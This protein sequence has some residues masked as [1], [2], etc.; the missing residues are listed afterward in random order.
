MIS[1]QASHNC[2]VQSPEKDELTI[3]NYKNTGPIKPI[4][5]TELAKAIK[6]ELDPL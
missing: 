4:W 3:H 2:Q 5:E 1:T 6:T